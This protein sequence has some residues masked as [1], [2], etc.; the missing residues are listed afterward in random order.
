[1]ATAA[2]PRPAPTMQDLLNKQAR[3]RDYIAHS[4]ENQ[5]KQG[6][7]RGG[8]VSRID[9]TD[10]YWEQFMQNDRELRRLGEKALADSDY[11][12]KDILGGVQ[13][14]Y[15]QQRGELLDMQD[16]LERGMTARSVEVTRET[17]GAAV[18]TSVA[19]PG[20][21][22]PRVPVPR[23]S[24]AFGEW[25]S[26]HDLFELLV[27]SNVAL[28]A[29]QKMH[30]LKQGLSGEPER[31]IRNFGVTSENFESAW[32]KLCDRYNN[33]RLL[34][35]AH[36]SALVDIASA[37]TET[38]TEVQRVFDGVSEIRTF[39]HHLGRPVERWDDWLVYLTVSKLDTATRRDWERLTNTEREPLPWNT[40][41]EFLEGKMRELHAF[42]PSPSTSASSTPSAAATPKSG[43]TSRARVLNVS[44][45]KPLP[46]KLYKETHFILH[47]PEFTKM[48]VAQRKAKVNAH[49]LCGNCLSSFH[50]AR[51]CTSA[52]RCQV[53]HDAH[54][55][56]LHADSPVGSD[57]QRAAEAQTAAHVAWQPRA[58]SVILTTARVRLQV[59]S[60]R[61]T[62][63]RA[64]V[65]QGSELNFISEAVA[66]RLQ[67]TRRP[68]RVRVTGMGETETALARAAT[69]VALRLLTK[70]P[71]ARQLDALILPRLTS[72]RPPV[73]FPSTQWKHIQGLELADDFTSATGIEAV[74]GAEVYADILMGDIRKGERGLPVA[75]STQ[76]GW[77]LT[78]TV[79]DATA[80]EQ[81]NGCSL[82]CQKDEVA[83]QLRRFWEV[84]E[85]PSASPWSKEETECDEQYTATHQRAA[86]G[87]YIVRLPRRE[88]TDGTKLGDS[89][90]VARASL[91]RLE[92][93][94]A[95]SST[96]R[97]DYTRFLRDYEAREHMTRVGDDDGKR[98]AGYFMPHHPVFKPT[99]DGSKVRVV[100]NASQPTS[101]GVSL[102][103]VLQVGP[104]LQQELREVLLRWRMHRVV[105]A[106][107]I[108]Q[109]F[110][111]IA[112]H[113]EDRPLQQILWREDPEQPIGCYRLNTVTYGTAS[114]PYLAI[115]TLLQLAHD[116]Q[117]R[118]PDAAALLRRGTYVD[119]VLGGAD[120]LNEAKVLQSDLR[121][122]LKAGGFNLRKWAS[123]RVELLE[124]IAHEDR[125][126]MVELDNH[127]RATIMLG[128]HWVPESDVFRFTHRP[129]V[130][131]R[132]TKRA[133]LSAIARLFDPLG[134][135]A[136][137]VVVAKI[138]LQEL[139]LRGADWDKDASPDM[140][141]RWRRFCEELPAV[142][143]LSVPRWLGW[144][145]QAER[146]KLHGFCDA[147]ERAYAA[148]AYLRIL[149][150]G[151][152]ATV[153]LILA[154]SK[155]APAKRV[156]LPRL[157]LCGAH[158]LARLLASVRDCI[159]VTS[160]HAWTDATIVLAWLRGHPSKWQTYVANRVAAIHEAIPG[161][162]WRHV[163]TEDNPADCA[164]RG[165]MPR[166]LGMHQIWWNGPRWLTRPVEEWP[167]TPLD[168]RA[169]PPEERRVV[170]IAVQTEEE[171]F[172]TR[173]S[174]YG[175]ALRSVAYVLRF[176]RK[177]R[178]VTRALAASELR[179]ARDT[180]LRVAQ[181]RHFPV[182]LSRLRRGA[183]INQRSPLT[184]LQPRRGWV[185]ARRWSAATFTSVAGG[186]PFSYTAEIRSPYRTLGEERTSEGLPRRG[187]DDL[188]EPAE[189]LLDTGGS[190]P[191][192]WHSS[193]LC[194]VR[195][196]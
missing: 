22:L 36:L 81:L 94:L 10:R 157:E 118:F 52:K 151:E 1:M 183:V 138:L 66:Q 99:P 96:L 159:P 153:G 162:V 170:H 181:Q 71:Y 23:F 67:V 58:K 121:Q 62:V 40:L 34:V 195:A 141:T 103:D 129:P 13:E 97:E 168:T 12:R 68:V 188:G 72:Y 61:S 192:P 147:S 191:G 156:T 32:Q 155:V 167:A 85:L 3:L 135:L 190:Q 18:A 115:R 100:F 5:R 134:W 31:L 109:M 6:R 91:L 64:L 51:D 74:L 111:Q 172:L 143:D 7:S 180:L 114:A 49:Q 46:G 149:R 112:V 38:A 173:F 136:P 80:S 25:R 102:N 124:G 17:P 76:L 186:E 47:C 53:C 16:E 161:A 163:P 144:F 29:V 152:P 55:T 83:E 107:D 122:L 113:P 20:V 41:S 132:I 92:R 84:K 160:I 9:L 93:R 82:H 57:N 24:G 116:E 50:L 42:S 11:V 128:V 154:K 193:S 174:T 137:I 86:D 105:F 69:T 106:A 78:G 171:D 185:A 33:K 175:R 101:T 44:K 182:E 146:V 79:A 75:Q 110:R 120:S 123:S 176:L 63:V 142:A 108:E 127:E 165:L 158:L 169:E 48:T 87:R 194:Y 88:A 56:L 133:I 45:S 177:F 54:H 196:A 178:P 28:S 77:L 117:D 65:D 95:Q 15:L 60:G 145:H 21:Q 148:V 179:P 35:T 184:P 104:R 98:A 73:C 189:E 164:S 90:A 89:R 70:D 131:P 39:L 130:P 59:E 139:W 187:S 166:D 19:A 27:R 126:A 30:Y 4:V 37:K 14:I 26:Y 125:E 8:L 2:P 140:E 43:K 150:P 119:D